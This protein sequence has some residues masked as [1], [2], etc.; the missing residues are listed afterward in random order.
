[1]ENDVWTTPDF[2]LLCKGLS[3]DEAKLFRK[4]LAEWSDGDENG[5]PVQLALADTG[6]MARGGS[7]CRRRSMSPEN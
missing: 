6:A 7:W 2:D 1:L 4:I 3:A 5:F